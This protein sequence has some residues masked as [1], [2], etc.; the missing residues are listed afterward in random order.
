M[1]LITRQQARASGRIKYFTGRC[2]VRGH[3]AE[4]Y[5]ANAGCVSCH[6][7]DHVTWEA[8]NLK[9]VATRVA[10]NNR[11]L[12]HKCLELMTPKCTCCG[13]T[14]V[15]FLCFDHIDGGGNRHRRE[16]SN[17]TSRSGGGVTFVRYLLRRIAVEGVRKVKKEFRVL[18]W[19]CN[20]AHGILGYC[21]HRR[22]AR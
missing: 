21:P 14:E 15:V 2:C 8:T 10:T 18:C 20:A 1:Q 19:N 22:A 4:R 11:A 3:I 16:L 13:E 7:E 12:R 5:V 17:F 9:R 6:R